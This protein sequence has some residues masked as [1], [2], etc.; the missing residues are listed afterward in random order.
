MEFHMS[1][2]GSVWTILVVLATSPEHNNFGVVS[3][4]SRDPDHRALDYGIVG[5]IGSTRMR[6]GSLVR[7]IAFAPNGALLVSADK[8]GAIIVWEAATARQVRRW[9]IPDGVRG[10]VGFSADGQ[11][12]IWSTGDGYIR[13]HDI[14]TG[15][16]ARL[17]RTGLPYG[18][19]SLD[20]G[21]VVVTDLTGRIRTWD[22]STGKQLEVPGVDG[23]TADATSQCGRFEASFTSD[24]VLI[25]KDRTT[26]SEQT[27]ASGDH[28]FARSGCARFS[29][30]AR[31]LYVTE[32]AGGVL[33]FDV[34]S[35]K[36]L[37]HF[38][39]LLPTPPDR[40]AVSPDGSCLAV[41]AGN[42]VHLLD[43]ATGKERFAQPESFSQ[44]PA[45]RLSADGR[46]LLLSGN[47]AGP[48]EEAWELATARRASVTAATVVDWHH[49][50]PIYPRQSQDGRFRVTHGGDTQFNQFDTSI[51]RI[52]NADGLQSWSVKKGLPGRGG[53]GFSPDD[54]RLCVVEEKGLAVYQAA[55]GR[56]LEL[57]PYTTPLT[58]REWAGTVAFTADGHTVLTAHPSGLASWPLGCSGQAREA[59]LARGDTLE[60]REALLTL[61]PD[62]RLAVVETDR[63]DL[64]IY[65]VATLQERFRIPN[66]MRG[67]VSSFLFTR[68]GRYLIVAN[69][70][71]T[72][73]L[74]DLFAGSTAITSSVDMKA[75]ETWA[76]LT[77]PAVDAFRAMR[78]LAKDPD[79]VVAGLRQRI[80]PAR[81]VPEQVD[82]FVRELDAP[83]YQ[84]RELA[85]GE[86]TRLAHAS[87]PALLAA[88]RTELS[89]EMRQR[90]DALLKATRGPDLSAEGIHVAR[91][92]ELLER[93]QTPQA[94]AL[95][96]EWSEGPPGDTL[97]DAA[98]GALARR[99]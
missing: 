2:F 96:R 11:R 87:R 61:S 64:L 40:M 28:H 18:I 8:Q 53:Y 16:E 76:N 4:N 68:D 10:P 17:I 80:R 72:V 49:G 94:L 59:R 29:A 51:L 44:P 47:Y 24:T 37:N 93:L 75:E 78:Q 70:D 52:W 58:K 74:H 9:D 7:S 79:A 45:M 95:L 30:D 50:T 21:R 91:A 66:R 99:R 97:A 19:R 43:T 33:R 90:V 20:L 48:R 86:L 46:Y 92:V 27:F 82:R 39:A 63:L 13:S 42:R 23:R 77:G 36:L 60:G 71:S 15:L 73:T 65:E 38:K 84:K 31:N 26:G 5:R 32:M 34:A 41:V 67:P 12:I 3:W 54:Q 69:G 25:C 62:G 56:M 57:L 88:S 83:R 89:P 1:L 14:R 22:E 55:S 85:Q 98:R 35:G 81:P 6:H